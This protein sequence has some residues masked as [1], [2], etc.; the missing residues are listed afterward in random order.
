VLEN[1]GIIFLIGLLAIASPG[2]DFFIILRSSLAG[3]RAAFWTATGVLLGCLLQISACVFGISVVLKENERLF[4][5]V[6][7]L[8]ALYLIYLGAKALASA[9]RKTPSVPITTSDEVPK[10][11]SYFRQG[12]LC[13]LLN[14]KFTLFLLSVF[15]QFTG[16][17]TSAGERVLYGLTLWVQSIVYWYALV[18]LLQGHKVQRAVAKSARY[19]DPIL[20]IVLAGLGIRIL[21]A[22]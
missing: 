2:P 4:Q 3:R 16:T 1:V 8:G 18:A 7:W 6:K 12:L 9:F 5:A 14:P 22:S 13:N 11:H 17:Q 20:G 21:I 19:A 15:A 10:T